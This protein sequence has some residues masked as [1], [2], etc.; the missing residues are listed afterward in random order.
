MLK[1]GITEEKQQNKIN[2]SQLFLNK[3]CLFRTI[4]VEILLLHLFLTNLSFFTYI[5]PALFCL[6]SLGYNS[7]SRQP[8]KEKKIYLAN[9]IEEVHRKISIE[10]RD[11][12]NTEIDN[13]GN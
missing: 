5:S 10:I 1:R 13:I 11:I 2:F 12:D 6:L 7:R 9:K 8:R 3:N 4:H